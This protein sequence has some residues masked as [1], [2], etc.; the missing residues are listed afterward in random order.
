MLM[1]VVHIRRVIPFVGCLFMPVRMRM[2]FTLG[3]RFF[4]VFMQVMLVIVAVAMV[5]FHSRMVMP[6]RVALNQK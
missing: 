4:R 2:G 6:V 1:P 3:A 5:V